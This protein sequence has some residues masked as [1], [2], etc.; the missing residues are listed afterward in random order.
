MNEKKVTIHLVS[1]QLE[2]E[3]GQLSDHL[4]MCDSNKDSALDNLTTVVEKSSGQKGSIHWKAKCGI[5]RIVA[6]GPKSVPSI[7]FGSDASGNDQEFNHTLP[8][9]RPL[10]GEEIKEAYYIEYIT[11]RDTTVRID[12]YIDIRPPQN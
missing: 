4:I 10:L 12:P 9:E 5:K 7:I 2:D 6:I 8:L 3:S 11:D 1:V